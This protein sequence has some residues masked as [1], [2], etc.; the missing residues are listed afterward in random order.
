MFKGTDCSLPQF[1]RMLKNCPNYKF[2]RYKDEKF[3]FFQIKANFALGEYPK[4]CQKLHA[5][6]NKKILKKKLATELI[7]I[8][9]VRS[10]A[11]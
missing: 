4:S 2:Y 7:E 3:K 1:L 10:R 8:A 9:V 6:K 11:K 5:R